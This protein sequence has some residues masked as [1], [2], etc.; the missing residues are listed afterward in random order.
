M[1]N[2]AAHVYSLF[3]VVGDFLA[4]VAAF[5]VAYVLRFKVFNDGTVAK[6]PGHTFAYTILAV[7]PLWLVIHAFIGLYNQDVYEK[8]FQELGRLFIGS[9]LGIL[10]FIGYDFMTQGK[11]FPGRLIPVY[12]FVIG[13]A[14][15][16][17]FRTF[18]RMI[19]RI[20]FRY[21]FGISNVLIIGDTVASEQIANS[22]DDT[23]RSGL[24][25]LG[26]VGKNMPEYT[27]FRSFHEAIENLQELP[28]G[29][30]QTEL[31]KTQELN[32]EVLRYAQ[33]HHI[34][35]R[36]VPGNNDLFVGNIDVELFDG[37]P[38]IA[39]HQTALIGW[40]RVVKRLFDMLFA[41]IALIIASPFMLLIDLSIRVFDPRGPI[42]FRQK[43]LTRFNR[44]FQV[45][46]FRT[47][48]Q[49]YTGISPEEAFE[50]M[51][52][53][54]LA[55]VYRTNG[56]FL[57]HDPRISSIGRFLRRTSLDELPQLF[58][59]LRGDISLVGPRALVPEELNEYEKRHT[60]LSVKSG[61]T[62]LAQ[63][64]GRRDIGFEERR[65]I[66][67]YYVQNWSFWLDISIILRTLRV[68]ITGSG[69][70]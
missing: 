31:Y 14:F 51:G 55:E 70:K 46:K 40:G 22:I 19:R 35:Y 7:L 30:I 60:I 68:V 67:M 15:L 32:D 12:G 37:L 66:D 42:L 59:V 26:M 6:I 11:L 63:I 29:I 49:E 61:L 28:H 5:V 21:G 41:S 16:V 47:T 36:F 56:D 38:M 8:R 33:E 48:K 1:R 52:K 44:E 65:K 17:L 45:Y 18:A 25:I 10:T 34:A 54:K 2:N 4:L 3:L 58:N 43:R 9:F 53:P 23:R 64:S 20:L 39:V 50:K 27:Y 57:P 62:G 13:F 69:A 24:R